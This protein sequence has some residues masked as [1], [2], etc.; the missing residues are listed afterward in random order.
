LPA[1]LEEVNAVRHVGTLLPL[2]F[3]AS[4][5]E[6]DAPQWRPDGSTDGV[7][8][9]RRDVPGSSFD[10]LR[11]SFVSPLSLERLCG[12]IYP[13][14][15]NNAPEAR[16][17]KR[18]LLKQTETERWTYEQISVPV[19]SDRDYVMHVKLNVPA[20]TGSCDVT[21]ETV[22]DASRPPVRGFVRIPVIRGHWNLVPAT[23]GRV[24]VRYEI[25][26]E[27]GGAVP[28]FLARS[29][30]RS[31]AIDFMKIILSRASAPMQASSGAPGVAPAATP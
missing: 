30:Q 12:A 28:A 6:A 25:F 26:S 7:Q 5:A 13:R 11:L 19:V 22:E 23:D 8:V 21:F 1:T 10:E 27:P 16:F 31:A 29:R 9:E 24:I 14:V 4:T 18:E 2:L 15:F 17:K 20:S 3:L